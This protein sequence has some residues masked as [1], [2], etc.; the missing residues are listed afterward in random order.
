[1]V[2]SFGLSHISLAT[3]NLER[4][5][6]FYQNVFGMLIIE[7]TEKSLV[8]QTPNTHDMLA[9]ELRTQSYPQA[10]VLHFGFRLQTPEDLNE[11]ITLALQFGGKLLKRGEFA[12]NSPFAYLADPEGYKIE[13]W[14]Q[15]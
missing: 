15:P 6:N 3:Q 10:G 4:S 11:A 7:R 9:L 2:R 1:M 5:G 14:Y 8:L 12:K 13:L